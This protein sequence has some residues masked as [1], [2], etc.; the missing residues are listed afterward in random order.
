MEENIF[1]SGP[2]FFLFFLKE[3]EKKKKELLMRPIYDELKPSNMPTAPYRDSHLNMTLCRLIC[4]IGFRKQRNHFISG[5]LKLVKAP[6]S[7]VSII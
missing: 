3:K 2:S 6:K 7:G 1:R 5:G 4:N